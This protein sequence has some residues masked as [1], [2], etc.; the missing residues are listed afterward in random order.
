MGGNLGKTLAQQELQENN[1]NCRFW[2]CCLEVDLSRFCRTFR[3]VDQNRCWKETGS[4][5][6][7]GQFLVLL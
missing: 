6:N 1:K 2:F 4:N 3:S 7:H 5:Q